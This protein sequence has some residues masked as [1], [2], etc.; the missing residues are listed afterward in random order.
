MDLEGNE[1]RETWRLAQQL[2]DNFCAR[3]ARKMIPQFNLRTRLFQRSEAL[4]WTDL[5][6]GKI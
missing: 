1:L 6:V 5:D 2:A 3:F 4:L